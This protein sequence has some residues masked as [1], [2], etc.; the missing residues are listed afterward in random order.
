MSKKKKEIEPQENVIS[1]ETADVPTSEA[2]A[3]T[4]APNKKKRF[5][6]FLFFLII[7]ALISAGF[8]FYITNTASSNDLE[9]EVNGDS[10]AIEIA[11][12]AIDEQDSDLPIPLEEIVPNISETPE[13]DIEIIKEEIQETPSV[14]NEIEEIVQPEPVVSQKSQ[15]GD[16]ISDNS[17]T[18]ILELKD[19]FKNGENCRPL[20]EKLIAKPDLSPELERKLVWLLQICLEPNL[21]KQLASAFSAQKRTALLRIFQIQYPTYIAYLKLIPYF[22]VDVRKLNPTGHGP[23]DTLD[24]IQNAIQTNQPEL[25]LE[26]L[27]QLPKSVQ[28][29]FY[30]VK[31]LAQAQIKL[32]EELNHLM[33]LMLPERNLHD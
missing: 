14:T 20:L 13:D 16:T 31:T 9:M 23:I 29:T 15:S 8:A 12:E 1:E 7:C 33:Q 6:K 28:S 25:V 18:L 30:D 32:D 21:N 19:A 10:L 24:K 27:S 17:L 22:L 3:K 5:K 2:T 4:L 11:E 26:L